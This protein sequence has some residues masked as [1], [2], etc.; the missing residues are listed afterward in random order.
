[1][2]VIRATVFS[3]W[4]L[5]SH[6]LAYYGADN[7]V[8]DDDA[9]NP[10]GSE[11]LIVDAVSAARSSTDLSPF[12]FVVVVH[13]G[14]DQATAAPIEK[15]PLIWSRTWIGRMFLP[16]GSDAGS[17]VSEFS[18]YGVWAHELG[19]QTGRL[20]DMYDLPD[21]SLHFMGTW[22]LM[23]IGAYLGQPLGNH[24][25]LFDAWSRASLGWIA[26]TVVGSG[27]YNL[28][29]AETPPSSSA[30]GCCYALEIQ[31]DSASYYL[32]ELRLREGI[33]SAQRT[34]GVLIYLYNASARQGQIRVVDVHVATAPVRGDL[35]DAALKVG[36][37]FSDIRHKIVIS[38]TSSS[39]TGYAVHVSSQQTYSLS[40]I[41]PASVNVLTKQE[42]YVVL[43]PPIGG[44]KLQVFLDESTRSVASRN[45]TAEPRYNFTLYLPPGMQ[46]LHNLTADL[47]DSAG[48][49]LASSTVKFA[50]VVPLWL[51]LIQ[52]T[53]L[54]AYIALAVPVIFVIA[55]AW[56]YRRR[57]RRG[58]GVA[59]STGV[60]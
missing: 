45:T 15:S 47:S 7:A 49:T 48:K 43:N 17:I 41:L 26:P 51:A 60:G 46:G 27:D 33:D 13:A 29:P 20:P 31:I 40:V 22:S 9:G 32:V 50:A 30:R 12:G 4:V 16:A 21:S 52:P 10:S 23:D 38:V 56:S 8:G 44:L 28:I 14:A 53:A 5:L 37:A 2:A 34:Q 59:Q 58:E 36:E 24:P 6:P 55:V 1:N 25:G 35:S 3:G 19:H 18:P 57:K 11:R 54:Y 42:F 39:S